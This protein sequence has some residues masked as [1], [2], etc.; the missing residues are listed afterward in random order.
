MSLTCDLREVLINNVDTSTLGAFEGWDR[1]YPLRRR[2]IPASL[3]NFSLVVTKWRQNFQ[4]ASVPPYLLWALL[5]AAEWQIYIYIYT[6]INKNQNIVLNCG[7]SHQ[8]VAWKLEVN[9]LL[10]SCISQFPQL[11]GLSTLRSALG[12]VPQDMR[13]PVGSSSMVWLRVWIG[14][15]LKELL[16]HGHTHTIGTYQKQC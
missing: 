3:S 16:Y 8:S 5:L 13:R 12:L 6:N 4:W 9:S 11:A 15:V 14:P 2:W 7:I 1:T 10:N